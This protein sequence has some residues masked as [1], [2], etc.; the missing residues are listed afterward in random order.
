MQLL[1]R[2]RN[3]LVLAALTAVLAGCKTEQ[4][5]QN[6]RIFD[7]SSVPEGPYYVHCET[8]NWCKGA[9]K[10]RQDA[11]RI[12]RDH[13]IQKHD[14]IRVAYYDAIKCKR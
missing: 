1:D 6:P 9:Y 11:E 7:K 2:T 10:K 12:S 13:N 8:C 14:Y 3:A 5:Q 4:V